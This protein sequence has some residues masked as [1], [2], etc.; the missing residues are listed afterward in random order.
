MAPEVVALDG[1]RWH[2][3]GAAE[4]AS[5]SSSEAMSACSGTEPG[6]AGQAAVTAIVATHTPLGLVLT[7]FGALLLDTGSGCPSLLPAHHGMQAPQMEMGW[8]QNWA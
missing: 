5:A 6:Q 1:K 8:E 3:V 4:V 2:S 7:R